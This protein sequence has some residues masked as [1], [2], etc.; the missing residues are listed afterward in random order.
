MLTLEEEEQAQRLRRELVVLLH[1]TEGE[2]IELP[3]LEAWKAAFEA[4]DGVRSS[5]EGVSGPHGAVRVA[6]P[7]FLS[8]D[9]L[10][11]IISACL[12]RLLG[13]TVPFSLRILEELG[14]TIQAA[15][16]VEELWLEEGATADQSVLLFTDEY[17]V[18]ELGILLSEL[19]KALEEE[20]EASTKETF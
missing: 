5:L 3:P 15:F 19:K 12:E 18:G 17:A 11:P 10:R 20:A 16:D 7:P 6:S 4:L 14:E 13:Q 1:L 2:R 8:Q 9:R